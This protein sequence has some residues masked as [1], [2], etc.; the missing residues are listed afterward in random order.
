MLKNIF[1]SKEDK[2][3]DRVEEYFAEGMEHLDNKFY[4]V[5]MI[6]FAKAMELD[7]DDV[8]PRLI[9]ELD[10]AVASGETEAAL[11]IGLNLLKQK[12]DDFELANKLGNYARELKDYKQANGLYKTALKINKNYRIAYYNLAAS[13]AKVDIFDEAIVSAISPFENLTEYKLP[14][15]LGDDKIVDQMTDKIKEAKHVYVQ[16]KVQELL[17]D[18]DL[19]TKE[20]NPVAITEID[21]EIKNL[22]KLAEQ[23]NSEDI[24]K[25]F[26]NKIDGDP[27]NILMHRFNL[28]LY[29]LANRETDTAIEVLDIIPIEAVEHLD[30][31][32]AIAMEQK[33]QLQ[34]AIDVLVRL[35]GKNEYN[36]YCNVNLGLMLRK[37]NKKFLSVKYLI[38]TA[39][40]LKKS[41]GLYSMKE[42]LQK[43]NEEYEQ[44]RNKKA[45]NHFKIAVTEIPDPE[46]WISIATIYMEGKKYDEAVSALHKVLKIDPESEIA[47]K[48]LKEIHDHYLNKGDTLVAERKFKPGVDYYIRA[49]KTLKLPETAKKAADIYKQ[50]NNVAKE[51]EMRSLW[52]KLIAEEK[53]RQ[54]EEMRQTL[55]AKGKRLLEE[56]KISNAIGSFEAAFLMK[57]DHNIF[58]QL[59]TLYKEMN[60]K[61]ELASLEERWEKMQ[62]IEDEL[63]KDQKDTN[64]KDKSD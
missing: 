56:D 20:N 41:N 19:K 47:Q 10:N 54:E 8:F 13:I 62:K 6:A 37:A 51:Q 40:L 25:E 60:K 4:N 43:A 64:R 48:R 46:I 17:L 55:I 7:P 36:R 16:D 32:N 21:L 61:E 33:G 44:G 59:A 42:L 53:A 34:E 9:N 15:Y 22:N 38:K 58:L 52:K 12:S 30:L 63:Q 29:S 18:K 26:K 57:V 5:A 24:I 27:E 2:L 50:M 1:Q 14:D 35:L 28:I 45:L 11:A 3:R 39:H 31:L 49:F 23:V